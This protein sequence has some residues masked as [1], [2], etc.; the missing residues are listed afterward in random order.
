MGNRH[1]YLKHEFRRIKSDFVC[2]IFLYIEIAAKKLNIDN[3]NQI[4]LRILPIIHFQKLLH[5]IW[6]LYQ[7][8]FNKL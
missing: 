8:W 4:F 1:T 5:R 3:Q 6:Q 7:F 2:L